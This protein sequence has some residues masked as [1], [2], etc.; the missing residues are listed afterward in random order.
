MP[1]MRPYTTS[2]GALVRKGEQEKKIKGVC[3]ES[4]NDRRHESL[5]TTPSHVRSGRVQG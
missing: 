2:A 3:P 5:V 4:S 1:L